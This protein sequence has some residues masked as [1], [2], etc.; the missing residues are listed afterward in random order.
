MPNGAKHWSFTLNNYTQDN[1]DKLASAFDSGGISYL[2]FGKEV[3]STGTPHLQGAVSFDKRRTMEQVVN[4]L[5]QAHYTISRRVQAAIEYCKKAGS[6]TEYGTPPDVSSKQGERTDLIAFMSAVK[7]GMVDLKVLR[8][9]HPGVMARYPR[10]VIMY[11]RDHKPLPEHPSH[12]LHDWQSELVDLCSQTPSSR[13]VVFVI[14][15][16]G[17]K[18]KSWFCAYLEKEVEG[19]QVMKCGK[20]DDMAFELSEDAK[21]IIVDVAR[22]ASEYLSYQLLEDIK[23]GRVFSPKYES[24]TKR[25]P[26]PHLI[27]FM[28]VDPD[29][30]KLSED[31]Y[32]IHR[33]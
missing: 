8:E 28:N 10:F 24:H 33:I 2:I 14:D 23:D 32:V 13:H 26:S 17:G 30:T 31:R 29:L 11:L 19:V 20:R 15:P 16:I 27:V 12:V 1:E 22:S 9:T 25:F 7:S 6:F 3:S 18:G 21:V 5:G 4:L